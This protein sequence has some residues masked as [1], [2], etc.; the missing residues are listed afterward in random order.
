MKLDFLLGRFFWFFSSK[1]IG[2]ALLG[3]GVV[4]VFF[5]IGGNRSS[6][7]DFFSSPSQQS[8]EVLDM[9]GFSRIPVLRGGRVKPL[10]SVAR[11]ALLVLRNKR[12]ALDQNDQKVPAIEWLAKVLFDH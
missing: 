2:Y 4:M 10:D 9:D 6:V 8:A 3:T 5:P 11:N 1:P 12:T 7:F